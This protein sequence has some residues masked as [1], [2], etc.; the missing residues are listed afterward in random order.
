MLTSLTA[1]ITE[2]CFVA[3]SALVLTLGVF[4][5]L[6][7]R[8]VLCITGGAVALLVARVLATAAAVAWSDG[9]VP[10]RQAGH[11]V[12]ATLLLWACAYAL[13]ATY[14]FEQTSRRRYWYVV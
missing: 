6:Q 7:F 2:E 8:V 10:P 12:Q 5:V 14:T 11:R 4:P 9:S 3:S 13:F 1:A